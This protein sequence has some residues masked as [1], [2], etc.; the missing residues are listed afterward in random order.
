MTV[1]KSDSSFH[2]MYFIVRSFFLF[3]LVYWF[4]TIIPQQK[5]EMRVRGSISLIVVVIYTL[6]DVVYDFLVRNRKS[7]CKIICD[8]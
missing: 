5:L 2:T 3:G 1:N 6:V 4:T 8:K 7:T